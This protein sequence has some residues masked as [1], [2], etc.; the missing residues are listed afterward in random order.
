VARWLAATSILTLTT[1]L[2]AC[3]LRAVGALE[4]VAGAPDRGASDLPNDAAADD[5]PDD[6]ASGDAATVLDGDTKDV[7]ADAIVD[8]RAWR[9]SPPI[10]RTA[11]AAEWRAPRAAR[12]AMPARAT[13][14]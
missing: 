9:T 11:E 14:R 3:G 5:D 13:R 10:S 12:R 6:G 8:V 4:G 1:L 7:V 2:G